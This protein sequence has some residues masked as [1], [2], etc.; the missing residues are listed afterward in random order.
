MAFET[1]NANTSVKQ[2]YTEEE[3]TA[4]VDRLKAAKKAGTPFIYTEASGDGYTPGKTFRGVIPKY[5]K[6]AE[7]INVTEAT[8]AHGIHWIRTLTPTVSLDLDPEV[9]GDA[10]ADAIS[11]KYRRRATAKLKEHCFG[12]ALGGCIEFAPAEEATEKK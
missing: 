10:H 3:V 5:M 9:S 12:M 1:S 7:A 8:H 2:R 6:D 4:V 11:S